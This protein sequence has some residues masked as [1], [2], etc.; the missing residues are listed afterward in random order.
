MGS[1]TR[2]QRARVAVDGALVDGG[3]VLDHVDQIVGEAAGERVEHVLGRLWSVV[4]GSVVSGDP[5]SSD[6]CSGDPW[7]VEVVSSS[8]RWWA[9]VGGA[10][11]RS[12]SEWAW[13][14]ATGAREPSLSTRVIGVEPARVAL[15]SERPRVATHLDEGSAS[16]VRGDKQLT[17][18]WRV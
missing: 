13:R 8:S 7:R 16:P 3:V 5:W 1:A 15:R 14:M 10:A 2:L 12:S 4:S 18:R 6:P 17:M 9:V 11:W